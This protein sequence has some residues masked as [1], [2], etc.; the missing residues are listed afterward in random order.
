M[1][2]DGSSRHLCQV[3]WRKD[4]HIGVQFMQSDEHDDWSAAPRVRRRRASPPSISGPPLPDGLAC[5]GTSLA[6]PLQHPRAAS[7]NKV[8]GKFAASDL[9]FGFVFLL[10]AATALFY[11]AG[12]EIANGTPWAL[13]LCD[14]AKNLC[15]HPEMSGVP[16]ILLAVV[17]LALKGMEL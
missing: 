7:S 16:A 6:L 1:S 14:S 11:V 2:K 15:D 13:Q 8:A 3:V 9:A 10:I 12:L 17:C 5:A 4:R